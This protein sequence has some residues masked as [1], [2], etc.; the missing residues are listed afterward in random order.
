MKKKRLWALGLIIGVIV[1][2]P[3]LPFKAV[4][5]AHAQQGKLPDHLVLAS[6]GKV[7]PRQIALA[8]HCEKHLGIPVIYSETGGSIVTISKMQKGKA[9]FCG[10]GDRDIYRAWRGTGEFKDAGKMDFRIMWYEE[11]GYMFSFVTVPRTGI[12]SIKDLAGKKVAFRERR[13]KVVEEMAAAI[14]EYYG[15][16]AK[17]AEVPPLTRAEKAGALAEG[18]VDVTFD[19]S[20]TLPMIQ[21]HNPGAFYLDIPREAGEYMR[22]KYPYLSWHALPAKYMGL[23]VITEG[24]GFVT[25]LPIHICR[26]TLNDYTVYQIVK[27][28]YENLDE[29]I[30][31]E[32]YF[33]L[34]TLNAAVCPKANAPYHPGAIRYWRDRGVWGS[35]MDAVQKNLLAIRK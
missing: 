28:V 8:A 14:L 3:A 17:V 31:A 21:Q 26:T 30:A 12:K 33:R 9:D 10:I 2:L 35:E 5:A 15:L 18:R 23:D 24:M 11:P 16:L 27:C 20:M 7:L 32:P 34:K 4:R 13:A 1:M 6:R 19:E 22:K 29:L 25:Q